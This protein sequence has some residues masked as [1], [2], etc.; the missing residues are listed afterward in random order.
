M[1]DRHGLLARAREAMA[2]LDGVELRKASP[3]YM[4]SPQDEEA[5]PWFAN[6]VVE[7]GVAPDKG[8]EDLLQDLLVIEAGLGRARKEQGSRFGPRPI[9]LDLLLYADVAYD[10]PVLTVPHPR[11]R[12]RAFV[13]QPL[14]DIAPELRFPDGE[15]LVQAIAKIR[16]R[17]HNG[18]ILQ[19]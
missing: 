11:M 10:S 19:P 14:L 12:E 4:T 16:F 2:G 6:Q 15:P 17:V 7:L 1:G 3:V 18:D 13:L 8:P 5:Q 9:D